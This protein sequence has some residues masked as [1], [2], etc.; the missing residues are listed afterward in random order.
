[1]QTNHQNNNIYI[2]ILNSTGFQR[3]NILKIR[4]ILLKPT[5]PPPKPA[6]KL[7]PFTENIQYNGR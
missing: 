2:R 4:E 5:N 7:E 6:R 1:M 3:V